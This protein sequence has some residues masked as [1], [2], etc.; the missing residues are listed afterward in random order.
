MI[1]NSLTLQNFRLIKNQTI[2]LNHFQTILVGNNGVGKTTIVEALYYCCFFVS[3]RTRIQEEL[4]SIGQENSKLA[5]RYQDSR[6]NN[7]EVMFNQKKRNIVYNG[8]NNQKRLDTI[9]K[10]KVLLLNPNS[11]H[12]ISGMPKLRRNY[13]DLYISQYDYEYRLEL[14]KYNK[15]MKQRNALLK[16]SKIDDILL[17]VITEQYDQLIESIRKTRISFLIEVNKYSNIIVGMLSVGSEKIDL[18]YISSKK[19]KIDKEKRYQK[20]LYGLQYD[21]FNILINQIEAKK[22]ASQ[23]Q[24]RTIAM[25]LVLSQLE[26]IY[27]HEQKYP[28]VIIDDVHVELDQLR[29]TILFELLDQK[30]QAIFVSTTID[31]IPLKTKQNATIYEVIKVDEKHSKITETT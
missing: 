25:A 16:K 8:Q 6:S 1:I 20:N 28:L 29:Q 14:S 18:Q 15:L 5:I 17:Q 30:V 21:D 12:Y 4:I 10:I 22:Y 2:K 13:L 26:I 19:E 31:N 24:Q 3:F 27:S 9:G 11:D 7:L 23:G